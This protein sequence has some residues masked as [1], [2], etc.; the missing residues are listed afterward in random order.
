MKYAL[1]YL[2]SAETICGLYDGSVP[3]AAFLKQYF[4]QHKKFGSKDRRY[5]SQLCYS[6]YRLGR[7]LTDLSFSE[8]TRIALFLCLEEPGSWTEI[9]TGDWL[10]QWD[11]EA[12]KRFSFVREQYPSLSAETVFPCFD[13]ISERF[14]KQPFVLSHFIQPDLF[15][16]IRPG[17]EKTVRSQL[18]AADIAYR[19][20]PP[21]SLALPNASSIDKLLNIDQECVIQDLSS[22]RTGELLAK[23]ESKTPLAVWDCCAA[24]GGKSLL[25][26]DTLH[27]PVQLTV[28]DLRAS[29][30]ANLR[31]RFQAAGVQPRSIFTADLTQPVSLPQTFD[32][33]ICDAPCSGSG[34]WG[35]T[36]EQLFFF[37]REKILHYTGL[38][39]RITKNVLPYVKHNGYL[40]YITCSVFTAENEDIVARLEAG[41]MKTVDTVWLKGYSDR[42]DSMFASLL[43]RMD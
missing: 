4:Q 33:V 22:Q 24:S 9:I 1:Q 36:P 35:R 12:A 7:A 26:W 39:E 40:L 17:H 42:A 10:S 41:A 31:K 19:E 8:R 16:R 32:L 5:I 20:Y 37:S 38:Q 15:I 43:Q 25:A 14:D 23:T 2:R 34:T 27:H 3:L 11:R 29:I 18:A 28:S 13:A 30:I 6:Y 21:N